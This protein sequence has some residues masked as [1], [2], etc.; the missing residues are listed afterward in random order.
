MRY[1]FFALLRMSVI[2][3]T[4]QKILSKY[5]C[6]KYDQIIY[7]ESFCVCVMCRSSSELVITFS[8]DIIYSTGLRAGLAFARSQLARY[9][10]L[11]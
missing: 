6:R 9:I 11:V 4:F 7:S 8:R 5:I 10:I 3:N 1:A 2:K